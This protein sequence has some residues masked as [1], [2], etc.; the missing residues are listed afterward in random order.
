M[1]VGSTTKSLKYTLFGSSIVSPG[2]DALRALMSFLTDELYL[3]VM[4]ELN[5][6][7]APEADAE[8]FFEPSVPF[9]PLVKLSWIP[10]GKDWCGAAESVDRFESWRT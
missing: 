3:A 2:S 10:S 7:A 1:K 4:K 5:G 6:L 8:L 9:Y